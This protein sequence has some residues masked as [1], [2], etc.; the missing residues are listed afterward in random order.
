[1]PPSPDEQVP[2]GIDID[3]L[4]VGSFGSLIREEGLEAFAERFEVTEQGMHVVPD[5]LI[6]ECLMV[7]AVRSIEMVMTHPTL[8]IGTELNPL[9]LR[10]QEVADILNGLKE[11]PSTTFVGEVLGEVL[12]KLSELFQKYPV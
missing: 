8:D 4:P 9:L 7:A 3:S 11:N 6:L 12:P 5:N 1:M 2:G 10:L